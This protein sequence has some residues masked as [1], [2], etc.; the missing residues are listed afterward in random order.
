MRLLFFLQFLRILKIGPDSLR[1]PRG[2]CYYT[3]DRR[4]DTHSR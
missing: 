3:G 1:F 2:I 4:T